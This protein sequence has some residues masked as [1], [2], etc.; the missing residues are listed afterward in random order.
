VRRHPGR[1][2]PRHRFR[3]IVFDVDGTLVDSQHA[4]LAAMATAFAGEGLAAPAQ[5]DIRRQVGLGVEEA[6]ARLVPGEDAALQ[7]RLAQGFREAAQTLRRGPDYREPLFPGIREA[8]LDIAHPA[9]CLGIATGKARR[10]LDHTLRSHGLAELFHTLQTADRNPSKPHPAMLMNAMAETGVSPA[11]TVLIGDTA[12]DMEMAAAAGT[13]RIGVT[14]GYHAVEDLRAAGAHR[15]IGAASEL[16]P[17]LA[18]LGARP[19]G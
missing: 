8:L 9:V 4:I 11:E 1:S 10:G 2:P 15:I 3:L 14:W 17:A 13:A 19:C 18:E 5:A 16:G 7:R 6:L 12:F